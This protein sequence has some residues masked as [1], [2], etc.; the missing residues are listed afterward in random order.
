VWRDV[1]CA[2]TASQVAHPSTARCLPLHRPCIL[3]AMTRSY[4]VLLCC[5]AALVCALALAA[6][7]VVAADVTCGL[8]S[9]NLSSLASGADLHASDAGYDYYMAVCRPIKTPR[10]SCTA[11]SLEVA[12]CQVQPGSPAYVAGN[13]IAPVAWS[14]LNP[15]D[16][17]A[18]I[19]YTLTGAK[20]C[21]V[22]AS[23]TTYTSVVQFPCAKTSKT[24]GPLSVTSSSSGCTQTYVYPTP[25]SCPGGS[26]PGGD[27]SSGSGGTHGSSSSST[28]LSGADK[29]HSVGL[30]AGWMLVATIACVLVSM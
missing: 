20:T 9:Y 25:L 19:G 5:A 26:T 15:G 23:Q 3:T 30:S 21:W 7:S 18:G 24:S 1:M 10:S 29:K 11:G 2:V 28:G 14:Y 4:C 13:W 6:T 16:K 27:S 22:G 17:T 8:D 12:N